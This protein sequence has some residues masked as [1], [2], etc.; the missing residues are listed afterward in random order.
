MR[1]GRWDL[2]AAAPAVGLRGKTLGS[3]GLGNIGSEMFRLLEPFGLGRKLAS[4]PFAR[5]EHAAALG[6]E[7]VDLDTL[8]RNSDFITINCLL[9]DDTHRLVNARLL[10]LMKPTAYLINTARGPIVDQDDLVDAL[11]AGAIAGAGLDVFEAE[12]LPADHPLV[13]M[14]NVILSP[15][16]LAWTDDLYRDNGLEACANVLSVL[17]GEAPKYTVN[18]EVIQSADFQTK[19]RSLQHKWSGLT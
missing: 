8:F 11:Q 12:P 9:N 13:R 17:R 10:S 14:D 18:R 7:L 16:S 5:P 4:D 1:T 2:R 19:L 3:V 15:H 6:V